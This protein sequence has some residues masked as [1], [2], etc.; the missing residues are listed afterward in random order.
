LRRPRKGVVLALLVASIICIGSYLGPNVSFT[1][2]GSDSE[3]IQSEDTKL[4][5]SH[6][7]LNHQQPTAPFSCMGGQLSFV[8]HPDDDLLFQSPALWQYLSPD[9]CHTTVYMTSGDAGLPKSYS[10]DR[11]KGSEAA[12]AFLANVTDDYIETEERFGGQPVILRTLRAL[13]N[14][15]KVYFRLPDGGMDGSGI[16][17]SEHQ[18]LTQLLAGSQSNITNR[19]D[20]ATFTLEGLQLAIKEIITAR[21]PFELATQDH[22][23]EYGNGD[24]Y[25]HQAV[26]RLV[27][28]VKDGLQYDVFNG[29]M[30]YNAQNLPPNVEREDLKKKTDAFFLYAKWDWSVCQPIAQCYSRN[31]P[32]PEWLQRQYLVSDS[33]RRQ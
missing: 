6:H 19:Y 2:L 15:Q 28:G 27:A 10:E 30:G 16:V 24:H 32:E 13:P 23:S 8:A 7:T 11:E 9:S 31:R 5:E 4:P 17:E 1:H 18:S 33:L 26:A 14:I 20:T 22:L 3:N 21:R 29:Y 12:F 25:D